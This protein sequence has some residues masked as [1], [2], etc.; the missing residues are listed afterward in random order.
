MIRHEFTSNCLIAR[1]SEIVG[2][3]FEI[4][5]IAW[6]TADRFRAIMELG[7]IAAVTLQN[8]SLLAL[9]LLTPLSTCIDS[10]LS[11]A[12]I[13]VITLLPTGKFPAQN[14]Q[15]QNPQYSIDRILACWL[16]LV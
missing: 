7:V 9:L 15:V 10:I 2:L 6:G 4:V 11:R 16:L 3:P 8:P 14:I 13:L 1:P 5:C 12:S